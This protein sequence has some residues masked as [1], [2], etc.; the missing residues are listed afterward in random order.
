MIITRGEITVSWFC[1]TL[2]PLCVVTPAQTTRQAFVSYIERPWLRQLLYAL[3]SC[4]YLTLQ[5]ITQ[6]GE[7]T[8]GGFNHRT[9]GKD[10]K[11][12]ASSGGQHGEFV[13]C[14]DVYDNER[15]VK[16]EARGSKG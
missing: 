3:V 7:V 4:T 1:L 5:G 14:C 15:S 10:P 2:L 12:D 13:V 8:G 11:R 6:A 9:S 16:A